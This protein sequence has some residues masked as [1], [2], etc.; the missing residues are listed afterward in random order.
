MIHMQ[1]S[2]LI[3]E[4]S[5]MQQTMAVFSVILAISCHIDLPA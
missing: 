2:N 3:G 4:S 5:K 1:D